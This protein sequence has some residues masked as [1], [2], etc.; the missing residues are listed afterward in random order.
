MSVRP[1]GNEA[2]MIAR[3]ERLAVGELDEADRAGVVAWLE[4]DPRRWRLCGLAFLEAQVCGEALVGWSPAVGAGNCRQLRPNQSK[5]SSRRLIATLVSAASLLIAFGLGIAAREMAGRE[6]GSG[7]ERVATENQPV[8]ASLTVQQDSAF[9]PAG[10][11][12]IPVVPRDASVD[13]DRAVVEKIP[14][15]VR[16]QW[17]RRG[18]ELTAERR[19]L[20]ARLAD[21]QQ[22]VVPVDQVLVHSVPQKVY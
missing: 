14:E 16:E 12:Q 15:Y 17:E 6:L 18:F 9:G 20:F 21:G 7:D 10:A 2:A 22:V 13:R 1:T 19:Y 4:E 5:R 8:L 11:I 3:L